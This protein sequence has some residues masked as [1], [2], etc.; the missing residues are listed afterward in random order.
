MTTADF[1]EQSSEKARM[2]KLDII[3]LIWEDLQNIMKPQTKMKEISRLKAKARRMKDSKVAEIRKFLANQKALKKLKLEEAAMAR[4][5]RKQRKRS[6]E[7]RE[8]EKMWQEGRPPKN[9]ETSFTFLNEVDYPHRQFEKLLKIKKLR[10]AEPHGSS[11]RMSKVCANLP[12]C[13]AK[14]MDVIGAKDY[15]MQ[16]NLR[17]S[18]YHPYCQ[19]QY[20]QNPEYW[21]SKDH[22]QVKQQKALEE[23]GQ[24]AFISV[25]KLIEEETIINKKLCTLV[26]LNKMYT[27]EL[28]KTNFQNPNHRSS[29][30]KMKKLESSGHKGQIR[31]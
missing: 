9:K 25:C 1:S 8:K 5:E 16:P 15:H 30:S 24:A 7:Q 3:A 26:E 28:E 13:E 12:E 14:M 4:Q 19:E 10:L 22:E 27:A 2:A 20:M 11:K 31:A 18:K 17:K 23:A 21:R 29:K 6:Q